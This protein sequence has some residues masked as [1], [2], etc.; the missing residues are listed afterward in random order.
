MP[1]IIDTHCHTD[2]SS[3]LHCDAMLD[4]IESEMECHGIFA[5]VVMPLAPE[6]FDQLKELEL[7]VQ[8]ISRRSR[9]KSMLCHDAT[10]GN[11]G[12]RH[13]LE[14]LEI[15]SVA[16]VKFFTGYDSF[17]PCDDSIAQI[18]DSIEKRGK[19][20]KFHTGATARTERSSLR[21][22]CDPYAFDDLARLRPNLKIDCAHFMA[23]N[24]ISMAPVLDKNHN[25][26]TDLSGLI[27]SYDRNHENSYA[28]FVRYRLADALAYLPDTNQIMFGSDFPFCDRLSM[29]AFLDSFFE[30]YGYCEEQRNRIWYKNAQELY[31]FIIS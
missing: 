6:G 13:I 4:A 2:T 29:I 12:T 17:G 24:H 3:L 16:G 1:L 21:F 19:V 22:C 7:F 5:A 26:Y 31:G 15:D 30:E 9:L 25:I 10:T 8:C 18:L 27:D 23:P 14:L 20:A 28:G 11:D